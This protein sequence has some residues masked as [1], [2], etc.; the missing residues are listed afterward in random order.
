MPTKFYFQGRTVGANIF[1]SF[2]TGWSAGTGQGTRWGMYPEKGWS[3]MVDSDLIAFSVSTAGSRALDRQYISPP[4]RGQQVISGQCS[5]RLM[6][7]EGAANDNVDQIIVCLRLVNRSGTFYRA[8]G[9]N[10][11]HYG[12]TVEFNNAF[13]NKNFASGT[14]LTTITGQDGDR[15]VLEIGYASS[16]GGTTCQAQARWGD[17]SPDLPINETQTTD[18]ASWFGMGNVDLVFYRNSNTFVS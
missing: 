7:Q 4:L 16:A 5:G 14:S 12:N 13:R 17:T 18:G 2:Q 8:T 6:V 11:G 15:I 10:I 9:L 1:P 3:P